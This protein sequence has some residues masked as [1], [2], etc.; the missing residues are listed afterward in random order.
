M[1]TFSTNLSMAAARVVARQ[2]RQEDEDLLVPDNHE[3]EDI[4]DRPSNPDRQTNRFWFP[5]L[6]YWW[7]KLNKRKALTVM[8]LVY[9]NLINYMDRST[10]AGMLEKIKQDKN[11]NITKD[12]YLGLLQTAFVVWGA[13]DRNRQKHVLSGAR[14]QCRL[15]FRRLSK[16]LLGQSFT[17]KFGR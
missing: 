1:K 16:P 4:D 2:G 6:T 8:I 5:S 11:F 7:G 3:H 14:S 12:K 13:C 17:S 10:V 9:V 15:T